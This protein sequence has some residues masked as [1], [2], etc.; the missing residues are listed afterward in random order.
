MLLS[1]LNKIMVNQVTFVG[2]NGVHCLLWIPPSVALVLN[3]LQNISN[4][5]WNNLHISVRECA[6]LPMYCFAFF[7]STVYLK[8]WC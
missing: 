6:L 4:L 3:P 7:L 1:E 8:I 2:F 5:D